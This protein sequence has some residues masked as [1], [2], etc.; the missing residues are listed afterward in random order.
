MAAGTGQYSTNLKYKGCEMG[1]MWGS[2][3]GCRS[4]QRGLVPQ[5][6]GSPG[7]PPSLLVLLQGVSRPR[8]F[9]GKFCQRQ[10]TPN[11]SFIPAKSSVKV[12]GGV[13]R[14]I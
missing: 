1:R 10:K 8:A 12:V 14:N 4:G 13:S 6:L 9:G 3:E 7:L 11:S 2:G 5:G